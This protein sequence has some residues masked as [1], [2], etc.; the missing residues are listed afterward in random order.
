MREYARISP[1]YWIGDTGK[2]IKKLG[3]EAQVISLYLLTNPHSN[4]LGLY[5]LPITYLSHETGIPLE[6]ASK[7]LQS[8]IEA[9]F[10]DYD[11][12]A[13]V[14][15]IYEM[16]S[17]QLGK[18]LKA[19]DNQCK[20]IQNTY[21]ELPNNIFLKDFFE[22]YGDAFC[23]QEG[24]GL[25]GA[26]KTLRSKEKEKEKEKEISASC[27]APSPKI[28]AVQKPDG[29]SD[30]LWSDL[31][32]VWKAKRKP[33]TETAII[34]IEKV[35]HE[36]GM[37]VPA[38]IQMIVE[39]NWQGVESDWVR[40]KLKSFPAERSDK[41]IEGAK[42]TLGNGDIEIYYEAMGWTLHGKVE[43]A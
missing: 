14:V 5:Y 21:N 8:L 4:M 35:S 11:F 22:K 15:F 7:G 19:S 29:V 17:F 13:E 37:T 33:I 32:V 26:C 3:L 1:R 39:S 28:K 12:D 43:A 9:G 40:N 24:R 27:E 2:K 6:G 41:P 16:A 42:R 36:T 18:S 34:K 23:M 20:G 31:K 10:C 38:V 30:Q 25:E